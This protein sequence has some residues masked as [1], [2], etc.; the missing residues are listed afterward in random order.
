[1]PSLTEIMTK[2]IFQTSFSISNEPVSVQ[3]LSNPVSLK[4]FIWNKISVNVEY[5]TQ[6]LWGTPAKQFPLCQVTAYVRWEESFTSLGLASLSVKE[7]LGSVRGFHPPLWDKKSRG[8]WTYLPPWGWPRA[9][10]S[11]H[12]ILTSNGLSE[13]AYNFALYSIL[14]LGLTK[15]PL[16]TH[17]GWVSSGWEL[18]I[19]PKKPSRGNIPKSS[20]WVAESFALKLQIVRHL[21]LNENLGCFQ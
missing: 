12:K 3:I 6:D 9:T 8:K 10:G 18:L 17:S 19:S 11:K 16:P 15:N 5:G 7:R 14:F 1:M 21:V 4:T 2:L 13:A 20:L